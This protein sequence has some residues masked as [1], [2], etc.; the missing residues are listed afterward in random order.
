MCNIGNLKKVVTVEPLFA[1][2]PLPG[3]HENEPEPEPV[4]AENEPVHI[5]APAEGVEC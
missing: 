1:P 3:Q 5:E 2:V 4:H